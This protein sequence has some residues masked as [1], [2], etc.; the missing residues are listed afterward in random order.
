MY[1]PQIRFS[2]EVYIVGA[3][4]RAKTLTE[5]LHFL[6][7]DIEIE[8]YLVDSL[9]GNDQDICGVPVYQRG[10]DLALNTDLTVFIATKSIYHSKIEEELRLLS[11]RHII[12]LTA[13][14]DNLL[15]NAYVKEYF[16]RKHF[17]FVKIEAFHSSDRNTE[18]KLT[19]CIYVAK[20][21]Y[22]KALQSQYKNSVYERALQVGAALTE[23][24]LEENIL[25]D[26]VGDNISLKNRQFCELTG[27]YWVWKHTKEEIVGLSHYRR[28]FVLPADWAE[29]MKKN[30]IDVI[31]PVPTCVIPS[32]SEN[33]R[34][35]HDFSDWEYL[36]KYLQENLPEDY[37][38]AMSVFSGKLYVPC[39]MFIMRREI[40]EELC[41]WL[42]PILN[43]IAE[44]GGE[45]SDAYLNR[46]P[47][48]ISER[49]ITL[50]F[51]KRR[52]KCKIVFADKSFL[53]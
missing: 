32:I 30:D 19:G 16:Q 24:R 45:K 26:D 15:R 29:I 31:L 46:Y 38:I 12:P 36:L 7:S 33:Y 48:F 8:A 53:P 39:N 44:H 9:S 51:Y 20:S 17:P 22:D 2:N 23:S 21:V 6:F 42:F 27:L 3:Q 1:N 49:M 40:L 18:S 5:Y 4:S 13:E 10:E 28:R 35:R 11:F 34:E 14:L 52:N 41:A 37:Q 43:A 25:T 50:F 47:G